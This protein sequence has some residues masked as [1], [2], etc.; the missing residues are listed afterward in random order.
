MKEQSTTR[1][2]A[3]L[4]AASMVVKFLSLFYVPFLTAIITQK[5]F[6]YY[7]GAYQIFTFIYVLT[8]SGI[9]VA[10]S[11]L[12]SELV[13]Q[14]N[15]KDAVKSF[16]IARF[17]LLI[18]GIVM[19]LML[20]FLAYPLASLMRSPKSYI[21]IVALAP[22][23]LITSVL[24]A[25]R[26]YF[27]G[28]ANMT[29][30]AVSQ[31]MEQ[32][33]NTTFSLIFAAILMRKS[34]ELGIAGATVGTTLGA[35]AA[36]IYLIFKYEK[37]KKFRVPKGINSEEIVRHTNKALVRKIISYGIPITLAVGLQYAGNLIDTFNVI[38][39]LRAAGFDETAA[40]EKFGA[41]GQMN[42]L[43]GVPIA[44]ISALSAAVLP[45]ISGASAV[46]DK[47]GV[48]EKI[49]QALKLGF[50]VSIPSAVGL[51]VLSNP[52]F[53]LLFPKAADDGTILMEFGAFV[54]ILMAIV[55]IQTT[56]LQGVGK[57][58]IVTASMMLGIVLK[59]TINYI[60]VA[61]PS[62]NIFGAVIGNIIC[63]I[64]PVIINSGYI[65]KRVKLRL[66]LIRYSTA[67]A[68]ASAF[69]GVM[70]YMV[71]FV[72]ETFLISSTSGKVAK[73]IVLLIAITVGVFIYAYGLILSGGIKKKD[74][75]SLSPRII[76]LIPG[77]MKER[78]R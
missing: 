21:S 2:F 13:A 7:N 49:N 8:N 28:R 47:K 69:M 30:T 45:S 50:M 73:I 41:L 42:T 31:I 14:H 35:L 59:I 74:L 53:T 38:R 16:K 19:S 33:I 64:V 44:L 54:V 4:S 66:G 55:Q 34:L 75:N 51:A 3:V 62:I 48:Q 6:G 72:L 17:I 10:I 60:L 25:Y 63:F 40:M 71:Y 1:G 15:Y 18:L 39:R 11:K 76:R 65:K 9:P 56:I 37:H 52:I 77:F 78:M 26:G 68:A 27:Q 70:V 57:L 58:Y 23:I 24:S 20:I 36:C 12:V 46:D 67:P 61:V 5:G 43:I 32:V 22:T 29:P